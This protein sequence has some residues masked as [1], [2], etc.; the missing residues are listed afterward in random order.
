MPP[1]CQFPFKS[2]FISFFFQSTTKFVVDF[3]CG[4]DYLDCQIGMDASIVIR[5]IHATS[6]TANLLDSKTPSSESNYIRGT[7]GQSPILNASSGRS[8]SLY[9]FPFHGLAQQ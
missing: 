1:V 7:C 4:I 6:L 3:N 5:F 9:M 2:S 8:A